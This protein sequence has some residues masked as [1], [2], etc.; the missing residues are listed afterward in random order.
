[1]PQSNDSNQTF[2]PFIGTDQSVKEVTWKAIILGA[3]ISVVFGVAN[4]YL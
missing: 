4:A 2:E 3:I 1:M